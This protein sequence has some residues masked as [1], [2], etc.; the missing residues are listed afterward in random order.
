MARTAWSLR[1]ALGSNRNDPA[2]GKRLIGASFP[3]RAV[4]KCEKRPDRDGCR[5]EYTTTGESVAEAVPAPTQAL[6][7]YSASAPRTVPP[8]CSRV[9]PG[10][11]PNWHGAGCPRRET[12]S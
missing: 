12:R 9:K 2:R 5:R 1:N 7:V 10:A 6:L 4:E 11:L 8:R 3:P